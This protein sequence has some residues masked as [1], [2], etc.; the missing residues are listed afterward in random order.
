MASTSALLTTTSTPGLS[1]KAVWWA[2]L[3]ARRQTASN[4]LTDMSAYNYCLKMQSAK[5]SDWR[6]SVLAAEATKAGSASE[7]TRLILRPPP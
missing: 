5:M 7:V 6:D 4:R 2:G 3:Q 1:Q